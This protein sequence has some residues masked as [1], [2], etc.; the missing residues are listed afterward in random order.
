MAETAGDED[1]ALESVPGEGDPV[2]FTVAEGEAVRFAY[3]A[4]AGTLTTAAAD[5]AA[6]QSGAS[7]ATMPAHL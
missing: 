1:G 2:A 4:E 6:A 7:E 3:D 5:P